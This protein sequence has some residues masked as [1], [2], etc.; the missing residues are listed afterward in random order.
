MDPDRRGTPRRRGGRR[1]RLLPAPL[2][3]DRQ[4]RPR[5]REVEASTSTTGR[6]STRRSSTPSSSRPRPTP[7]SWRVSTSFR[8]AATST[9]EKPLTL[10]IAEGRYLA[11][12]GA[13]VQPR[14]PDRLA[15]AVD[16]DQPVRQQAGPRR[17]DRQG[18]HRDHLQFPARHGLDAPD[19]RADPQ[20][21]RLGPVVQPDRASALQPRPPVRLVAITSTTTPAASRGA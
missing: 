3:R 16:A 14:A 9:A 6:C 8:P 5:R 11:Q 17:G 4:G 12:R 1:G 18:P 13:E 15:A 21:A 2:P 10:T 20:R 19:A 7:G